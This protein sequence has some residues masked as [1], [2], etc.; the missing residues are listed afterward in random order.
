[1]PNHPGELWTPVKYLWPEFPAKYGVTRSTQWLDAF[2]KCTPTLYGP[3]PYAVKNVA[4][5]KPFLSEIMLRRTWQQAGLDLPPLRVDVSLLE[6]DPEFGD[7]LEAMLKDGGVEY[8]LE[9]QGDDPHVSRLRH[10]L[11]KYKAGKVAKIL[12]REIEDRA[13]EKIVVLAYH[14]DTLD[15]LGIA[16]AEAGIDCV[17]FRGGASSEERQRAIDDFTKTK[18]KVFL[19][20]QSSAGISINLQAAHELVLL[21]PSWSPSEN[22]QAIKRIHRIGQ[23]QPCRARV[24]AVPDTLDDKIM[25]VLK[26][27]IRMIT[28]VGL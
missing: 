11:G 9:A 19:A 27:K 4:I 12:V 18:V 21:E 25:G 5:L 16:F 24:F 13:Y 20:Q 22:M 1:M 3:R 10:F 6:R 28:E 15:A 14:H 17:G 8:V 26:Q 7:Q 2:T 23:D